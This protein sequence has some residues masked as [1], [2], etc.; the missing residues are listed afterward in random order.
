MEPN[1]AIKCLM[2]RLPD[3]NFAMT[4]DK[5]PYDPDIHRRKQA[6][7]GNKKEES[8]AAAAQRQEPS[9]FPSPRGDHAPGSMSNSEKP[10]SHPFD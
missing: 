8:V 4:R 7:G 2:R 6:G 1:R 10:G 9:A 5:T 3:I